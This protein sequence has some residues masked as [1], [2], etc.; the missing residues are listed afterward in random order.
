LGKRNTLIMTPIVTLTRDP[1]QMLSVEAISYGAKDT[2]EMGGG[3]A[4][5]IL[6]GAGPELLPTLKSKLATS[7]RAVGDIV[8]TES[9]KLQTLGIRW[10]VHLISIIKHTPQGAYCPQPE[11]LTN[12]VIAALHAV[13]KLGARSIA[14]SALAT[15]EGRVDPRDAARY[16]FDGV[17]A[18]RAAEPHSS[19]AVTFSL[20]SYRDYEAFVS[21][22]SR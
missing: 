6:A 16:M 1:I 19:L 5:A 21:C 4:A 18:F 3:A 2:G 13:S 20:P 22:I 15:G 7:G 10:I 11:R 12:G 14:F 9:F 17:R 8:V